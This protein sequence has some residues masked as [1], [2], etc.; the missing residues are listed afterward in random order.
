[1][2]TKEK[3][4]DS[5]ESPWTLSPVF[6]PSPHPFP[7]LLTS[8]TSVVYLYNWWTNIE[9]YCWSYCTA[10]QILVPRSGTEPV[11]P[12][13]E[14][15]VLTI[16][17]PGKSWVL[18]LARK[19]IVYRNISSSMGFDKC[20]MSCISHYRITQDSFM[21]LKRLCVP[22]TCLLKTSDLFMVSIALPFPESHTV[23]IIQYIWLFSL[24]SLT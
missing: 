22:L 21:A 9:H 18:W 23:G 6:L 20:L 19:S 15:R 14:H 10:C 8:G 13:M 16:G 7:S 5:R 12:A 11:S 4:A 17:P 2:F 24:A 1:M 3:E